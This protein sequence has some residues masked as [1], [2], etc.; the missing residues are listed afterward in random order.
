[1]KPFPKEPPGSTETPLTDEDVEVEEGGETNFPQLN[2]SVTPKRGRAVLWPSV[3]N[4]EP[5]ARAL[6]RR[7]FIGP[8]RHVCIRAAA[9]AAA[10]VA[11]ARR[12]CSHAAL[13][14]RKARDDRTEH[15]AVTV[16]RGIKYA[17]N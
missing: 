6:V 14:R 10:V 13:L 2:I 3:L 4:D 7:I 8:R 11:R 12:F 17:A 16:G 9:A 5:K 1:M 15:E